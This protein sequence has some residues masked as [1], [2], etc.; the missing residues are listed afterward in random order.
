MAPN[1]DRTDTNSARVCEKQSGTGAPHPSTS[2]SQQA[3]LPLRAHDA[4]AL[5][6]EVLGDVLGVTFSEKEL[7]DNHQAWLIA[8]RGRIA[9]ITVPG[10]SEEV[11]KQRIRRLFC[12]HISHGCAAITV[13]SEDGVTFVET[14]L[15][16]VDPAETFLGEADLKDGPAD[17]PPDVRPKQTKDVRDLYEGSA[18]APLHGWR[19]DE[20]VI[21][22]L[23]TLITDALAGTAEDMPEEVYPL[24]ED[25]GAAVA[26]G[27]D[28]QGILH[29]LVW[30]RTDIPS[31][32]R[33]DLWGYCAALSA[34]LDR[35]D[36][37]PDEN[38]IFHVRME[39]SPVT[40]PGVALL[41]AV[42]VQRLGRRPEDCAFPLLT[43][44]AQ[45]EA[46]PPLAA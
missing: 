7:I 17:D 25:V 4:W 1:S 21:A 41:A 6:V 14:F 28:E 29:P 10:L 19:S 35:V 30:V 5:P 24:P 9:V 46:A 16:E 26:I 27:Y 39:R 8:L 37:E 45:A 34:S 44:P 18:Y 20:E 12:E 23:R 15:E 33:A 43:P 13:D 22:A 31:G 32:L 38:G 36:V 40:G 42:T 2:A 3:A 11:K